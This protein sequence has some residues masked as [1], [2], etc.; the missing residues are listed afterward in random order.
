M[1]IYKVTNLINNKCYIGQTK[2]TLSERMQNHIYKVNT[3]N[4]NLKFYNAI[5]KYGIENFNW[6]ILEEC[7]DINTLNNLEIFYIKKYDSF[8][9]GYNSN[10]GIT[11]TSA[12]KYKR[13]ILKWKKSFKKSSKSSKMKEKKKLEV[14]LDF[15]KRKMSL[16]TLAKIAETKIKND[17]YKRSDETKLK[18]GLAN[19]GKTSHNKGVPMLDTQKLKISETLKVKIPEEILQ[20]IIEMRLINKFSIYKISHLTNISRHIIKRLLTEKIF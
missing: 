13:A 2:K 9:N 3:C 4:L 8:N 11:D 18:I 20:K 14:S 16:E 19:K 10:E 6:E 15:K 12:T 17:S 5:R 1:I 7:D